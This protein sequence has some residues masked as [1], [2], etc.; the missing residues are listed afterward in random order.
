MKRFLIARGELEGFSYTPEDPM[1]SASGAQAAY[2][3]GTT[4]SSTVAF[5]ASGLTNIY[6]GNVEGGTGLELVAQPTQPVPAAG[7]MPLGQ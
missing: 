2:N 6:G 7:I 5:D 4:P 3:L 1:S